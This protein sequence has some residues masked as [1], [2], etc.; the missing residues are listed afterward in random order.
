MSVSAQR[1]CRSLRR[2]LLGT[3]EY[4]AWLTKKRATLDDL[5]EQPA[6]KGSEADPLSVEDA[7]RF[8]SQVRAGR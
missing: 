2:F 4:T 5:V 8:E 6:I 3:G 1:K 7:V